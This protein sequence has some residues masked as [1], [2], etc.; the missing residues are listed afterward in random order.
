MVSEA[1]KR[2]NSKYRRESMAQRIVRFSP[3]ESD[4]LEHL[5]AQPNRAGYLKQLIKAD[6][7]G[8]IMDK[9]KTYRFE[10]A[11][12][13]ECRIDIVGDYVDGMH[14]V[15]VECGSLYREF[16][17]VDGGEADEIFEWLIDSGV[18]FESIRSLWFNYH[19]TAEL[20][21]GNAD[22]DRIADDAAKLTQSELEDWKE[23]RFDEAIVTM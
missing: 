22:V 20:I 19:Y 14:D 21:D 10:T 7:E 23:I 6:M 3:N 16:D 2:A 9:P 12:M 8:R 4:L 18:R 15:S 13:G 17:E 5:D 11:N 1:Q